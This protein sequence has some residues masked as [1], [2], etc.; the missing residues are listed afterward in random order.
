MKTLFEVLSKKKYDDIIHKLSSN[1]DLGNYV[2]YLNSMLNDKDAKEILYKAF[3]NSNDNETYQFNGKMKYINITNLITT[4][5]EIDINKSIGYPFRG[6]EQAKDNMS[7]MMKYKVNTFFPLITY[8]EK[9]ILDGHHRWAKVFAF[10]SNCKI[11]CFDISEKNNDNIKATDMLKIIQGLLAAKRSQDKKGIL[12]KSMIDGYNIFN[13]SNS[14]IK[15]I[16]EAYC[17]KNNEVTNIIIEGCNVKNKNELINLLI[18]NL[19]ILKNKNKRFYKLGY[20]R[21]IMPQ[22]DKGG[23][24]PSDKQTALPTTKGSAINSILKAKVDKDVI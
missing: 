18:N 4:Q 17:N 12:P 16:I 24:D 2:D 1:T 21:G 15:E 11:E 19:N 10:N 6:I 8:N 23:D 7:S 3:I 14:K 13:L 9:Y 5:N 22:T 20:N